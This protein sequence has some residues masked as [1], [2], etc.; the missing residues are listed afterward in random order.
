MKLSRTEKIIFII[1]IAV[2]L[3]MFFCSCNSFNPIGK[4]ELSEY[5]ECMVFLNTG[6][7]YKKVEEKSGTVLPVDACL[8]AIKRNRCVMEVFQKKIDNKYVA[9]WTD[10]EKIYQFNE[11]LLK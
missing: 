8:K 4:T 10:K 9:D 5:P 7:L 6:E 3:I 2:A 11:C 1:C